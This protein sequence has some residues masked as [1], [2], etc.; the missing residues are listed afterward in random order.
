MHQRGRRA[1]LGPPLPARV[2]EVPDELLLLGVHAD[3]RV[4]GALVGLDLPVYVAE[5]AVPVRVLLAL[6]GLGVALQAEALAPQKVPDGIGRHLVALSGQLGREHPGRLRRPP[7]RRHRIAPLVGLHQGQQRREQARVQVSGT[8]AAPA[9][10]PDA[11]QRL[12]AGIQLVSPQRD[13]AL[14]DPGRPGHHPD[15][16]VSQRPG[17]SP[18]QQP[19]LPLVQVREDHRELRRQNLAR[20]LQAAHSTAACRKHGSDG[21]FCGKP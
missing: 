6:N 10:T 3:H 20:L 8:L 2:A 15:A 21:L 1:A 14:T 18:E 4:C 17:L 11:P 16:A 7:Q 9:R 19:P 13:R 12:H 5:L